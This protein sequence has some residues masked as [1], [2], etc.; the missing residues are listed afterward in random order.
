MFLN[1]KDEKMNNIDIEECPICLLYITDNQAF[2]TMTCCKKSIHLPCVYQWYQLHPNNNYCFMCNQQNNFIEQINSYQELNDN[3]YI[4]IHIDPSN[5]SSYSLQTSENSS[6]I[7]PYNN[8]S[9]LKKVFI[10]YFCFFLGS[11]IF[12]CIIL[13]IIFI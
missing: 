10:L 12:S 7:S 3:S 2:Y 8:L 1:L 9:L 4:S 6:E 5:N 13:I 11:I